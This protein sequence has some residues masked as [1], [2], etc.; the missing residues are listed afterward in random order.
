MK[1][2]QALTT[3]EFVMLSRLPLG[4]TFPIAQGCGFYSQYGRLLETWVFPGVEVNAS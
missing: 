2:I 1:V 4:I 3:D